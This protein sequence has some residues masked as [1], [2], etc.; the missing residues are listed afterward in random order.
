MSMD[1]L[2]PPV[3]K[4]VYKGEYFYMKGIGQN[5]QELNLLLESIPNDATSLRELITN[6][7]GDKPGQV[8]SKEKLSALKVSDK[9]TYD[10][11]LKY[12]LPFQ[13]KFAGE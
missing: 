3:Q 12:Y 13:K 2:L 11:I 4:S 1:K 10:E 9:A 7:S 5:I 6:I 8:L